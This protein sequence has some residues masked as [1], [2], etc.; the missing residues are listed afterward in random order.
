M[1]F[2]EQAFGITADNGSGSLEYGLIGIV[3]MVVLYLLFRRLQLQ[4]NSQR[5]IVSVARPLKEVSSV[6]VNLP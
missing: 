5:A 6:S 2:L 4:V 1:D 3:G